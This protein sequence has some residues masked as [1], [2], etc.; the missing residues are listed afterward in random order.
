MI[1]FE[2][3]A[4]FLPKVLSGE[5][6]RYGGILKEAATGRIVGHLKEVG[7]LSQS[8]ASLPLSPTKAVSFLAEHQQLSQIMTTLKA[9]KL[10]TGV[11][12]IASVATLGVS[13]A[14]FVVLNK[15]LARME[16]RL[17]QVFKMLAEVKEIAKN[18]D[19]KIDAREYAKLQAS[20]EGIFIIEKVLFNSGEQKL[21]Q[22]QYNSLLIIEKEFRELKYYY[23]LLLKNKKFSFW[24]DAR[25][26]FPALIE[27]FSHFITAIQGELYTQ[28]LKGDFETFKDVLKRNNILLE[29]VLQLFDKKRIYRHRVANAFLIDNPKEIALEV[30]NLGKILR[31]S[32]RRL[33][34]M[35]IEIDFLQKKGLQPIEYITELKNMESNILLLPTS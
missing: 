7:S 16:G 20:M 4:K 35:E 9:L 21:S 23:A 28:F 22:E 14:G 12:A 18:I 26:P 6:I 19:F 32:S 1:P 15:K 29:E 11:G 10:I 24:N 25:V 13:V 31:E 30:K 5:Y 8:L 2:V 3:P 34:T 33:E 27:L 17:E